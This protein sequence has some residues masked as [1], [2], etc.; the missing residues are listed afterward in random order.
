MWENCM[1]IT[2]ETNIPIP[3]TRR[4]PF[5]PFDQMTGG[6]SFFIAGDRALHRLCCSIRNKG[7]S[8]QFTVRT[9]TEMVNGKPVLGARCFKL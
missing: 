1:T 5:Y 6:M 9:V 2:L 8:N 7:L 3:A 4:T